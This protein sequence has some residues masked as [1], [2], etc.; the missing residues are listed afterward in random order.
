MDVVYNAT[1]NELVRTKTLVKGAIVLIDAAPFR[2]WY[3]KYYNE[4]LAKT[5]D[6]VEDSKLSKSRLSKVEKRR[7]DHEIDPLLKEQFGTGK[8]LAIIR[9]SPGQI[10]RAD[11]YILEG[12][13]LAFYLRK[14][15]TKKKTK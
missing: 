3:E 7:K 9:T 5:K 6:V 12:P 10:G 13:E 11:G 4:A 14:L 1:N 2:H 15:Q 8:L